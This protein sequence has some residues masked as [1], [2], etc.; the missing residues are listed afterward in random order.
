MHN[1]YNVAIISGVGVREYY[2]KNGYTLKDNYM[3]KKLYKYD[4][5]VEYLIVFSVIILCIS[6]FLDLYFILK[7]KIY[8]Y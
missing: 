1:I 5:Y 6:I 8:L 7:N 4:Y 3:M 2:M